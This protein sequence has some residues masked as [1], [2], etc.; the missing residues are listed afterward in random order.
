MA[1]TPDTPNEAFMR[2]VDENLR[3]DQME[4]FA[5]TYGK[6]IIAAVVLFLAAA[7]A[8]LYWQNKQEKEAAQRSEE[9]MSIYNDIGAGNA[10]KAQQRLQ[11]LQES[12][13][14]VVRTLALLT[15]AAIAMQENDR[16]TALARYKTVAGDED[17]PEAYRNLALVRSTALEFDS[18]KPEE[19]VSRLQPLTEPGN[20]WFGSAGELTAMAY[21]KQG[22][23]ERA[24]RLFAAIAKDETVTQTLRS[25]AM[26][27][28]GTLGVDASGAL[29][30]PGQAG[31]EG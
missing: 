5:K 11:P 21:L 2:E 31:N 16:T 14:D 23:K 15:D 18:L 29:R 24:G 22:Q 20:P 8:W 28:A 13:Q 10:S 25:R 30:Q 12:N 4:G 17:S 26:Q 3:R 27:I 7:G 19:V 6:W 1:L 9:L